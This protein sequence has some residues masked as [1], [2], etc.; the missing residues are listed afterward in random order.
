MIKRFP[1]WSV[2]SA[3]EP[4]FTRGEAFELMQSAERGR[5]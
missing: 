4:G 3:A 2:S 1:Q 5:K